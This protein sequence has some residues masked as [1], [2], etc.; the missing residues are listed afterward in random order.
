MQLRQKRKSKRYLQWN[1]ELG[2]FLFTETAAVYLHLISF[3]NVCFQFNLKPR[4]TTEKQMI[5]FADKSE[6]TKYTEFICLF[7]R[8]VAHADFLYSIDWFELPVQQLNCISNGYS[9]FFS[10]TWMISKI[11][12][13][14]AQKLS[15]LPL[16]GFLRRNVVHIQG[17]SIA[18]TSHIDNVSI[19]YRERKLSAQQK[20]HRFDG[21][22]K[23]QSHTRTKWKQF[24][25]RT[26]RTHWRRHSNATKLRNT[27][28]CCS[29]L[30]Y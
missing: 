11:L 4:D 18:K 20:W 13:R 17:Y 12:R 1:R 26:S 9:P 23:L 25:T 10:V 24:P 19:L 22:A 7:S 29:F 21:P 27:R 16:I 14:T 15:F 2:E 28:L 5:E 3:I 6:M 8:W 30:R